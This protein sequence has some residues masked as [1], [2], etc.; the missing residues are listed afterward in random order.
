MRLFPLSLVFSIGKQCSFRFIFC[1]YNA[2]KDIEQRP[3]RWLGGCLPCKHDD[4]PSTHRKGMVIH[5]CDRDGEFLG[6]ASSASLAELQFQWD[7]PSQMDKMDWG[8]PLMLT[9]SLYTNTYIHEWTCS[10]ELVHTHKKKEM[11]NFHCASLSHEKVK[12]PFENGSEY[13]PLHTVVLCPG[14]ELA[15]LDFTYVCVVWL[16]QW[17]KSRLVIR[18]KTV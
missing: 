18:E 8:R 16:E 13:K 2:V 5:T 15:V 3:G 10:R 17:S 14:K 12:R 4:T 6:L 11:G 9:S 7:T 1:P